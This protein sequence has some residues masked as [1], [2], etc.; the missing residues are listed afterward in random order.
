MSLIKVEGIRVYAYHGHLPEEAT[1]GGHFR[2]NVY[3]T[4]DTSLVE[5]SDNLSDT[6]DYVKIIEVVEEEM[7]KRANMIE[8]PAKRIADAII[9][10]NHA[11]HVKVEL[12]KILPPI[13]AK[14]DNISVTVESKKQA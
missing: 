5:T 4:L 1:L 14:F 2:L 13:D 3:V 6:I 12:E 10:F 7:K 9:K 11:E 8:V